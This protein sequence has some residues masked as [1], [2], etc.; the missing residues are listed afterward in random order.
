MIQN[1][2][3]KLI[4]V[5]HVKTIKKKR[6]NNKVEKATAILVKNTKNLKNSVYKL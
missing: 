4:T 5:K 2:L 3:I 6:I 1:I